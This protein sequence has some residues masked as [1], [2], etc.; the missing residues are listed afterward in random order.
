MQTQT[1]FA[2]DMADMTRLQREARHL[3]AA[4]TAQM[5]AAAWHRLAALFTTHRTA[6]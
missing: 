5:I 6:S 4:F 3:R 2:A 1:D